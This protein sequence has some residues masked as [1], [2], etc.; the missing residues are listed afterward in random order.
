MA[1]EELFLVDRRDRARF[2]VRG[3]DRRTFLQGIL[4]ND[5]ASLTT[6]G[7][8]EALLLTPKGKLV[9]PFAVY[10]LGDRFLLDLPGPLR[11][12][13]ARKLRMYVLRSDVAIEDVTD[14]VAQYGLYGP[15][16]DAA[17]EALRGTPPAPDRLAC[18]ETAAAGAAVVVTRTDPFG[19]P[20]LDLHVPEESVPAVVGALREQG[21]A[22][23]DPAAAEAH[24][25]ASGEP[26]WGAEMDENLLPPEI[27][28][29]VPRAIS[30]T[31]GCY[32][33]Q[34]T[35]ARIR[36]Y[37]HVNRELRRL[38]VEGGEPPAPGTEL[39]AGEKAVG[40]V[41]SSAR[42]PETG[43]PIALAF[44]RRGHFEAGMELEVAGGG[45]ARVL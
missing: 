34:E 30:Y 5:V 40:A 35:I 23:M 8:A 32:T 21:A 42:H 37:G 38:E 24:R 18:V 20:G 45:R 28:V 22:T 4:S 43:Q 31:K 11:E 6:G 3:G 12:T 39:R 41:T 19:I 9:V 25:I 44:V 36:T 33:G 29:L 1:D 13:A 16:A 15:G 2:L 10:E 26:K 7:G 17:L 27:P 14:V